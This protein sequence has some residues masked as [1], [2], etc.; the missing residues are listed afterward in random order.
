MYSSLQFGLGL[1]STSTALTQS[2]IRLSGFAVPGQT[3]TVV[4]PLNVYVLMDDGEL[5]YDAADLLAYGAVPGGYQWYINNIPVPGANDIFFTVPDD[6]LVGH[7]VRVN[8]SEVIEITSLPFSVIAASYTMVP[9]VIESDSEPYNTTVDDRVMSVTDV[10]TIV[11]DYKFNSVVQGQSVNDIWTFSGGPDDTITVDPVTGYV[12]YVES[13]TGVVT[14]TIRDEVQTFT[15]GLSIESATPS[16]TFVSY[17]TGSLAKAA[18]DAIDNRIDTKY[19]PAINLKLFNTQD[20][21]NS[22]YVRNP[23]VWCSDIDLTCVSPWNSNGQNTKGGV[24]IS[25]RHILFAAHY[26][27]SVGA[28]VRFVAANGTVVNR[29]MTA[30]LTHPDYAPYYP[31]LTVGLLDTAVDESITFAKVLPTDWATYLPSIGNLSG[32]IPAI[33]LDQ[34]EKATVRNLSGINTSTLFSMPT[35]NTPKRLALY[36]NVITGDSGNPAFMVIDNAPVLLTVWTYGGTGSGTSIT[37][38]LT[39]LNSIMTTLGGGYQLTPVSLSS[40]NTY[41]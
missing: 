41:N 38:H 27:I 36:E 31:D 8:N 32:V 26:E 3:L 11:T 18:S 20:H 15:L 39:T 22:I 19:D 29:I 23:D 2:V 17:E 6:A 34:E 30:K 14:A 9:R 12:S 33:G 21:A 13:G 35:N 37:P 7:T 10:T 5:L 4:N 24:L 28:T 25:P 16:S 1:S 40:Y